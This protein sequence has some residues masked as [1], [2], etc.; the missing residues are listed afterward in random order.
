MCRD[1]VSRWTV[2]P[3]CL[4]SPGI[5]LT[6]CLHGPVCAKIVGHL[7][8]LRTGPVY[9]RRASTRRCIAHQKT[10]HSP[11]AVS[12]HS[13]SQM[14]RSFS[15]LR[16]YHELRG[17]GPANGPKPAPD[18]AKAVIAAADTLSSRRLQV[19]RRFFVTR[20]VSFVH[21]CVC[22]SDDGVSWRSGLARVSGWALCLRLRFTDLSHAPHAVPLS[23][24]GLAV[25]AT[26]ATPPQRR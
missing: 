19:R 25:P 26:S 7:S 22:I 20:R 5:A 3:T 21:L 8:V 14:F 6:I 13:Y 15:G 12:L 16:A 24:W 11:A 1:C 9:T 17:V 10:K 23:A 2:L 4:I 18:V